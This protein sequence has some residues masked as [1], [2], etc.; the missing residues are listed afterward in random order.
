MDENVQVS[1]HL[2]ASY[3]DIEA[4]HKTKKNTKLWTLCKLFIQIIIV[5]RVVSNKISKI[6]VQEGSKNTAR[7]RNIH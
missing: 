2:Q 6:S 5:G 1:Q 7:I 3:G 4:K